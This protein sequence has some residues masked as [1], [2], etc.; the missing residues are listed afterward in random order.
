[1]T[2]TNPPRKPA[3]FSEM[4]NVL[5][6]LGESRR[7][8]RRAARATGDRRMAHRLWRL[9]RRRRATAKELNKVAPP[10]SGTTPGGTDVPG[11]LTEMNAASEIGAAA[12]CLRANRRLRAAIEATL[13]AA[14]PRRIERRLEALRDQTDLDAGTFNAQ[15]RELVVAPFAVGPASSHHE[16]R[17]AVRPR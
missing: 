6:A 13:E 9:A 16:H 2:A 14:P 7:A 5:L 17:R 11:F 3:W 15:L 12:A 1:M 8:L 10:D 4:G